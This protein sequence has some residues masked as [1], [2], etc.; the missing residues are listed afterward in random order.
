MEEGAEAHAVSVPPSAQVEPA[1]EVSAPSSAGG[2]GVGSIAA[3]GGDPE[4]ILTSAQQ[5]VEAMV[6]QRMA[7]R[8]AARASSSSSYIGVTA[9][10]LA[11][12]ELVQAAQAKRA[13]NPTPAEQPCRH[14]YRCTCKTSADALDNAFARK[15]ANSRRADECSAGS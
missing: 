5:E 13:A 9:V 7:E 1:A 8:A 14:R 6:Q 15:K 2:S 4:S 11:V 12:G 3:K 10:I